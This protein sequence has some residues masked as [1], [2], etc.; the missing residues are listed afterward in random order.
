RGN[1][2]PLSDLRAIFDVEKIES[3]E[4]DYVS[5]VIVRKGNRL[6]GLIVDSFI[7]QQEVVL[8]SLGDYLT[9]VFAIS[10]ATIIGDGEVA[11]IIDNTCISLSTDTKNY[12]TN[13]CQCCNDKTVSIH[14]IIDLDTNYSSKKTKNTGDNFSPIAPNDKTNYRHNITIIMSA[15]SFFLANLS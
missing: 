12:E 10:G 15:S 11:L 5:I 8:K 1:V 4:D 2:V 6:T 13:I 7:G 14:A 3:T 9:N